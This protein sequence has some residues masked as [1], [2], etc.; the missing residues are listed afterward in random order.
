Y[1]HLDHSQL[2]LEQYVKVRPLAV[3]DYTRSPVQFTFVLREDRFWLSNQWD[4]FLWL[5][6]I[7]FQKPG[8]LGWYFLNRQKKKVIRTI[9]KIR[10][11]LPGASFSLVGLGTW[12]TFP[13]DITDLRKNHLSFEEEQQWCA[14]YAKSQVIIGVHGSSMLIPTALAGGY[15]NLIPRYKLPHQ[16][17]DILMQH[18]LRFAAFLGRHFDL[19]SA[20]D[21]VA[22]NAVQMIRA[23]P[24]LQS[25]WEASI[26][27]P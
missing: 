10:K 12:G 18:P 2:P 5:F 27:G 16:M 6:W 8:W 9:S 15:I 25:N 1:T 11:E 21:L 23:F 4:H 7:K 19:F 3:S 26:S 13:E 14:V 24:Y 17:E 20:P 22:E